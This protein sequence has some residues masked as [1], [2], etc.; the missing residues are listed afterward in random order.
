MS[1][2]MF[3]GRSTID[4][5]SFVEVM[6]G[7]DHKTHAIADF[8][9]GGGTAL[10]A[11]VVCSH[12]GTDTKLYSCFGGKHLY[13]DIVYS[14]V[15]SYGVEITDVCLDDNYHLPLSNIISARSTATRTIVNASQPDCEDVKPL[16]NDDFTDVEIIELDQ[17]EV[18]F[19]RKNEDII[20]AFQGE[21]VLDA[22][23]WKEH[24][25]LY[26]SL[27]TL[28]IVSEEFTDGSIEKMQELAD[29]HN[30]KRWAMTLGS[31]GI[32]YKDGD[33]SGNLEVEKVEAI[34]TLGA[35]DIFHGAFCH[36]YLQSKDFIKSLQQASKIAGL[37]CTELGTRSWLK[38]VT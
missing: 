34:D 8:I 33:N 23:T 12:L 35:G 27:C 10:N 19:I 3:L 16:T 32:Y 1:K 28:P 18:P 26:L 37:S 14:D 13:K 4:L 15:Q 2:S 25:D 6:P 7:P 29:K 30:I 9:G 21:I 20:R 22:G 11:A 31:K 38:K 36:Y 5:M 24:S 17:Y